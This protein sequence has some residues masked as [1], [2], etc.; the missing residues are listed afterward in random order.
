[1][2]KFKELTDEELVEK[3]REGE[4][5]CMDAL[6]ERYKRQVRN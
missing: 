4:T 6:I 1:M 2:C 5:I 3:I